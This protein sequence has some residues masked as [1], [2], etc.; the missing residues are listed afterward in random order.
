MDEP[1]SDSSI[2]L[3]SYVYGMAETSSGKIVFFSLVAMVII[4][5]NVLIVFLG[6]YA[7]GNPDPLHCY[8]IKG[9]DTTAIDRNSALILAEDRAIP[10]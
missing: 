5:F 2:D 3:L 6:I 1:K 4:A 7:Y 8:Y 10:V 9:V